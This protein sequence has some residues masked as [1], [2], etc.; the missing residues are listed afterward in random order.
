MAKFLQ[1]YS[2]P[3]LVKVLVAGNKTPKDLSK[4]GGKLH[5]KRDMCMHHVLEKCRNPNLSFYHTQEKELDS[6]YA[7][8][9][10]TV[11][12]PG[13]DYI[14]RNCAAD[15]TMPSLVVSKFK[16]KN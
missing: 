13:M 10:C 8:N 16:T 4:Y 2:A 14:C 1:K 12:A 6:Q 5:G 11:I 9:I 7:S 3:Y 15:I